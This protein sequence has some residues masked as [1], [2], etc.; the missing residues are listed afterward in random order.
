MSELTQDAMPHRLEQVGRANHQWKVLMVT[1]AILGV[2]VLLGAA[3]RKDIPVNELS[4]GYYDGNRYQQAGPAVQLG[5]LAGTVDV[6]NL[7]ALI[8]EAG[9]R[10]RAVHECRK[11][12]GLLFIPLGQAHAIVEKYLSKHPEQWNQSMVGLI[13]DAFLEP[14]RKRSSHEND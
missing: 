1:T 14:C 9:E 8:S 5:Y 2:M 13:E 3:G 10:A 12:S 11:A 7:Q 6:V 4:T